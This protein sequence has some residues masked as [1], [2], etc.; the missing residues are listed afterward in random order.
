MGRFMGRLCGIH[1]CLIYMNVLDLTLEIFNKCRLR[2]RILPLA[3]QREFALL[4]NEI[5]PPDLVLASRRS[6]TF[7]PRRNIKKSTKL[8]RWKSG[9][10]KRT[11]LVSPDGAGEGK[12]CLT[13][14]VLN[15]KGRASRHMSHTGL[16][17]K[18]DAAE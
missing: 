3:N 1:L 14:S 12:P 13:T 15:K 9:S 8:R 6:N 10:S 4:Y 2:Q 11:T 17:V 5:Y 18:G 7:N 16:K